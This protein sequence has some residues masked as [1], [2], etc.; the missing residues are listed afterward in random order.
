MA[1]NLLGFI[2]TRAVAQ[3]RGASDQDANRAGLI[4]GIVKPPILGVVLATAAR[5][6]PPPA[7]VALI[8]PKAPSKPT[9]HVTASAATEAELTWTRS[10]GA[11]NYEI[12]RHY[13]GEWKILTL[14]YH[15]NEYKDTRLHPGHYQYQ[16]EAKFPGG[17]AI[18]SEVVGIHMGPDYLGVAAAGAVPIPKVEEREAL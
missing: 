12:R 15:D 1:I 18:S 9:L 2:L 14:N 8:P 6:T 4:G 3:R 10:E 17:I 16:I 13:D 7:S 11:L 5:V